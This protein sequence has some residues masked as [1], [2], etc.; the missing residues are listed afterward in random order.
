MNIISYLLIVFA[1]FT[2]RINAQI[3]HALEGQSFNLCGIE[4]R[5]TETWVHQHKP[6]ISLV[7]ENHKDTF[8]VTYGEAI[9]II[10]CNLYVQE[11]QKIGNLPAQVQLVSKIPEPKS[12]NVINK[13]VLKNQ[14]LYDVNGIVVSFSK[15]GNVFEFELNEKWKLNL[16]LKNILWLGQNAFA[17]TYYQK[18]ELHLVR[19]VELLHYQGD[20]LY[21]LAN[22]E[23][24]YS[25]AF[26]EQIVLLPKP[27][28]QKKLE[29]LEAEDF[30]IC[31]VRIYLEP[32]GFQTK[33]DHFIV[34]KKMKE[35]PY[36]IVKVFANKKEAMEYAF[37]NKITEVYID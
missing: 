30:Q 34:N 16:V 7:F 27:N 19:V 5:I 37:Q 32:V 15:K 21:Q 10:P 14:K 4:L 23:L 35:Y 25:N 22:E 2:A 33:K 31:L 1:L 36:S 18:E 8:S 28:I 12:L 9:P 26:V 3:I 11:I 17:L 29:D 13:I 20:T 6:Y 24:P